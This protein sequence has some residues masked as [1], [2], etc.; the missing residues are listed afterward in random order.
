MSRESRSWYKYAAD[1]GE[2]NPIRVGSIDGTDE[3]PHDRAI[4]RAML[5]EYVPDKKLQGN[6]ANTLFIGRLHIKTTEETLYQEFK[7]YGKIKNCRVVRD[8]YTEISK[9]YAFIEFENFRSAKEAHREMHLKIIDQCEIVVEFE[10]GRTLKGWKPRRL[11]GGFGGRKE[12]GQLRFGC[13]T[14]P[15]QK[16]LETT[17]PIN[18]NEIHRLYKKNRKT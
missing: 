8:I 2:Y 12:S 4:V 9:C 7:R 5:T 18:F 6:P 15:F 11:G 14:R 17:K 3:K 16:P 13:R 1:Y 10:F